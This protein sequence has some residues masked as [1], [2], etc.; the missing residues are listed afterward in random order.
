MNV[1]R[2]FLTTLLTIGCAC[3]LQAQQL[4][5]LRNLQVDQL[6]DR[7]LVQLLERAA[8]EGLSENQLL[9]LARA[10]GL[11]E[12]QRQ[13]LAQ[14]LRELP[15]TGGRR[16]EGNSTREG[17]MRGTLRTREER[18]GAS[19]LGAQ[20]TLN[21]GQLVGEQADSLSL[22][23]V[24]AGFDGLSPLQKQIFGYSL[25]EG[26]AEAFAP[27]YNLATPSNYVLGPGDEIFVEIYG[28]S[29]NSLTWQINPEGQVL[30]PQLGPL[31]LA[32]LTVEEAKER[33]RERLA[34]QYAGLRARPADTFLALRV[35]NTR[36]IQ[37]TLVGDVKRPG[38]YQLPA[39]AQT[40]NALYAAGGPTENGSFR[41]IQLYR[42]NSLLATLDLYAFILEGSHAGNRLLQD[43]DV[44]VIPPYQ[45]RVAWEGA[46]RRPGLYEL[47]PEERLDALLRF[48][49][50]PAAGA[51]TE[52]LQVQRK[53]AGQQRLLSVRKE[54]FSS[55]ALADGDRIAVAEAL[56][57]IENRVQVTGSVFRAGAYMLAEGMGV[58]ALIQEAEGLREDAFTARATLYRVGTD[59][60]QEALELD[61]GAILSGQQPDISLRRE[62]V[63]F[64]RSIFDLQE[65]VFVQISGE[66]NRPGPFPFRRNMTVGELILRAGGLRQSGSLERVE[67]ARRAKGPDGTHVMELIPLDLPEDWALSD[68]EAQV[69]LMAFDHVF[70]RQ[71]AGFRREQLVEIQ[72]EVAFPGTYALRTPNERISD[73]IARAG[74]LTDFAYAP[75]A[76]L[77]RRTEFY[78]ERTDFER[79][80][81]ILRQIVR[82][83]EEAELNEADQVFLARL[84]RTLADKALLEEELSE[85][86]LLRNASAKFREERLRSDRMAFGEENELAEQESA[87]L[88]RQ[89]EL[90]GIDLAQILS[91]PGSAGNL[92]LEEGD[93]IRVPKE[94]QT[95]RIRG[96][97]LFPT[98]VRYREYSGLPAYITRSGGYSEQARKR[99]AY[100]VYANGDVKRTRSFLFMRFHP[101]I[102]PGSEIIVPKKPERERLPAQAWVGLATGLA[103][104]GLIIANIVQ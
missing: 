27:N 17:T 50:G 14:R 83:M 93:I 71:K 25:F 37:V 24:L 49:G 102:A 75:G 48:S 76:T 56:E 87:F 92:R 57:R 60:Q 31:T 54:A 100:V 65:E 58:R 5:D 94:L 53:E 98:T 73:V 64:V 72:G 59:M 47:R 20:A 63:L 55:F 82:R 43:N 26:A 1:I 99:K 68:A 29:E 44:I 67:I 84:Q 21:R 95:V 9:D 46:V 103:S 86:R 39:F 62:D 40:F 51:F 30:L 101:T 89:Q 61:L 34:G 18:T 66:V 19:V 32:G 52:R 8:E 80:E 33:L 79:K 22:S 88:F 7:Q 42:G 45:Q 10:Q 41:M 104:L 28:A 3:L 78:Q 6:S 2:Y 35:G 15:K 69:P 81:R 90:V 23:Q 97:V 85:E 70:V 38:T 74:G 12:R 13:A 77:I 4:N 11:P 96:E 91:S 16:A 36:S